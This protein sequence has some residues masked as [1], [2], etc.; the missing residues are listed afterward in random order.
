MIVRNC[1]PSPDHQ[2]LQF[3]NGPECACSILRIDLDTQTAALYYLDSVS[4]CGCQ[5][6]IRHVPQDTEL[7]QQTLLMNLAIL[8]MQ[9]DSSMGHN[10]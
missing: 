8:G 2:L 3:V 7:I 4:W 1:D 9:E 6:C 10:L 5:T